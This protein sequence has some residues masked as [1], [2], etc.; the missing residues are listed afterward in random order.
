MIYRKTQTKLMLDVTSAGITHTHSHDYCT[1][2]TLNFGECW[3][4]VLNA[5]ESTSMQSTQRCS[6]WRDRGIWWMHFQSFLLP[7]KPD[8][9][10]CLFSTQS[11]KKSDTFLEV[12]VLT[13]LFKMED[14][15]VFLPSK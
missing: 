4:Y 6:E 10:V 3:H 5:R 13:Y 9:S 2:H 15:L 11:Q 12:L 1:V 8:F 7:R 14:V